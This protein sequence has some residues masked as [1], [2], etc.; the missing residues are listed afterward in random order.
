MLRATAAG[1]MST[2]R[3][4]YSMR[5]SVKILGCSVVRSPLTRTSKPVTFWR[6]LRRMEITS[7]AVQPPRLIS[8]SS[9]G[10]A[11]W[12][13]PV[14]LGLVSMWTS[15]PLSGMAVKCISSCR[16]IVAFIR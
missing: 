15:W 9:I 8:S 14:S 5:M 10:L 12:R 13:R 11:P 7:S 3:T 6:F 2:P 4:T 16:V 1:S